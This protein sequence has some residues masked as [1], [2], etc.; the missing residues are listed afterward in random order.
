MPQTQ[1]VIL[2]GGHREIWSN[3]DAPLP[4][5]ALLTFQVP[6]RAA[7]AW[8]DLTFGLLIRTSDSTQVSLRF[9]RL[10]MRSR[11]AEVAPPMT[12]G[13]VESIIRAVAQ[14]A[15]SLCALSFIPQ[16]HRGGAK[17][18]P[19]LLEAE[20]TESPLWAQPT[21]E[22]CVQGLERIWECLPPLGFPRGSQ[23]MVQQRQRGLAAPVRALYA[24]YARGFAPVR[25]CGHCPSCKVAVP[26]LP[27]GV[28]PHSA[29]EDPEFPE[30]PERAGASAHLIAA[31]RARRHVVRRLSACASSEMSA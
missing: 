11:A 29:P 2:P 1:S 7:R 30:S 25:A 12:P 21:L 28:A 8:E 10:Y 20:S 5:S 22:A 4:R 19:V 14:D 9:A 16:F 26:V 31:L 15:G 17:I 6:R 27:S 13:D 3:G 23:A 24:A 18:A